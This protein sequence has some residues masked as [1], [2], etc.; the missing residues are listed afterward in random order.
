MA[1][2]LALALAALTSAA[3]AAAAAP[4]AA[5][6][7]DLEVGALHRLDVPHGRSDLVEVAVEGDAVAA[8][9]DV[10]AGQVTLQGVRPGRARVRVQSTFARFRDPDATPRL[11]ADLEVTV[12]PALGDG[13]GE[14]AAGDGAAVAEPR[15][16]G[17]G[18]WEGFASRLP[19]ER[20]AVVGDP[21][22]WEALWREAFGRAAPQVDFRRQVV[23]CVFLGHRA[24]W[25]YRIALGAPRR[26]PGV[27]V[28]PYSLVP[29][30]VELAGPY[31]AQGQYRLAPVAREAGR[32]VLLDGGAAQA[33]PARPAGP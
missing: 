7:L 8:A 28:V 27:L 10:L 25:P 4:P 22:A 23:A 24:G 19:E 20:A 18:G 9:H 32:A 6:P 11:V 31:R 16:T 2:T 3:P 5:R 17:D 1:R 14:A 30:V 12:R 13:L 21:A 33:G 15:P 29:L 26:E